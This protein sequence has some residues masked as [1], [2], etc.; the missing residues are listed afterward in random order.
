M[1][2]C[3]SGT[4][5]ADISVASS[6]HFR[7]WQLIPYTHIHTYIWNVAG[8]FGKALLVGKR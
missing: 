7:K 2:T 8:L 3:Y 5:E 1:E 4:H 6:L